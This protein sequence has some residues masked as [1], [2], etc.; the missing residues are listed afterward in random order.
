MKTI[1]HSLTMIA[2]LLGMAL[3]LGC[4][5][6]PDPVLVS[7]TYRGEYGRARVYMQKNLSKKKGDRDYL[8]DRMR[9]G[10]VSMAD[11]CD[12]VADA[13]WEE[14]YEVL[15]TQGINRDRTV[16]SVVLNE[17]LKLWKGEPFEQAL[18]LHYIGLHYA[19]AG[20]WDNT[21]AATENAL[22]YLKDFG[23][24]YNGQRLTNEDLVARTLDKGEGYLDNG[25]VARESDFTLGYLMNAIANRQ[26]GRTEEAADGFHRAAQTQPE[27]AE[28]IGQLREGTYN[29]LLVVDFGRGPQ[30][31][32]TGPDATIAEFVAL[33]PSSPQRLIVRYGDQ[34]AAYP[35][36]CDVNGMALDHMWNNLS[37]VR[38]A[39]S[40]IGNL[41]LTGGAITGASGL[42]NHS[43]AAAYAGLGMIVAGV[44]AKAG[45]HADTRYCE[46]MPQ[47]IY[48]VPLQLEAD[49]QSLMVQVEGAAA[50]RMEVVGLNLATSTDTQISSGLK[51]VYLRLISTGQSPPPW[52]DSGKIVY[53]NDAQPAENITPSL[54]YILGGYCVRTPHDAYQPPAGMETHGVD[55]SAQAVDELYRQEGIEMSVSA[56]Q[57]PGLHILEGGNWLFTPRPASAGYMRLF[58]QE[59]A[60]YTPRSEALKAALA[61]MH[62]PPPPPPE[63][64]SPEGQPA[65]GQEETTSLTQ[66]KTSTPSAKDAP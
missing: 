10:V 37:D 24:N 65:E 29:T 12:F 58:A 61:Q 53:A 16:A 52:A 23:S 51:V 15:R 39:K 35:A 18:A 42:Q 66:I 60:A 33:T 26:L 55:V 11:G 63:G 25:Y 41:L 62:S 36:V 45:A 30:K 1:G 40:V 64:P 8:L 38:Q 13:A 9:L 7:W 34:Q 19:M 27:L 14:V 6:P 32:G 46:V 57:W 28:L 44:F 21:R 43:E 5:V 3:G 47:R 4:T 22:F 59:H 49:D 48:V 56:D 20:S 50:S 54:P 17:D 2:G 31:I